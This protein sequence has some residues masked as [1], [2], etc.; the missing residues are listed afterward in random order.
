MYLAEKWRNR[1]VPSD[2]LFDIYDGNV[3]KDFTK[4][5]RASPNDHFVLLMLNIDW[6]EPFHDANYSCGAIY[7]TIN[8]LPR[9]E[10]FKKENVILVGVMPGPSAS[11]ITELN[12]YLAP[13]VD[14]LMVL[15][16]QG[17]Q[18]I[19]PATRSSILVK[20]ALIMVA[21][22]MPAAR[23]MC[24]F[25]LPMS[26][27]GC[28]KCDRTFVVDSNTNRVN[29]SGG[30]DMENYQWKSTND[31]RTHAVEW[32][33]AT[34]NR[35]CL[36]I[37][38]NYGTHWSEL[39]RLLYFDPVRFTIIDA[40]HNLLLGMPKKMFNNWIDDGDLTRE[41]LRLMKWN[42]EGLVLPV[43]FDVISPD[44]IA[45]GLSGLK[46]AEWKSWVLIYSPFLLQDRLTT[47]KFQHWMK[48]VNA[49][50]ILLKLSVIFNEINNI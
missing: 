24:G 41:D 7:L 21:C 31:V 4:S 23:K 16:D 3:W 14:E 48:L 15:Y 1:D 28:Y 11:H 50:R 46:A 34:S 26:R 40:M 6:F 27:R 42:T 8:N 36:E 17:I 19:N 38:R 10:R 45:A 9:S 13:L 39:H 30:Y 20:A 43:D 29:F 32:M 12:N 49:C 25:T 22:D 5:E 37:E 35:N 18:V 44:R 33:T 2:M 47:K